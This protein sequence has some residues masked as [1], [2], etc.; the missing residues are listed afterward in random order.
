M[1]E[2]PAPL[3]D[4]VFA[5][6][7]LRRDLLLLLGA[8]L[9]AGLVLALVAEGPDAWMGGAV[10]GL[11]ALGLLWFL[12]GGGRASRPYL[13]LTAEAAILS[14]PGLPRAVIPWRDVDRIERATITPTGWRAGA[15]RGASF[16]D[17]TAL[18]VPR[19]FY[20]AHLHVDSAFRRGP[21]WDQTY[22]RRGDE[23]MVALHHEILGVPAAAI[24]DSALARWR[25][26]TQA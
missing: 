5:A 2:P 21:G 10:A 15:A 8:G 3:P 16:T 17:V 1:S 26:A 20:E 19:A 13:T 12:T 18:A 6:R 25:A 4:L 11:C 14:P 24:H 7:G 9:A 22:V 23:V